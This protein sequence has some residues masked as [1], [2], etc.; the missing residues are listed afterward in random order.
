MNKFIAK[1]FQ[2]NKSNLPLI[3]LNFE[4]F[5]YEIVEMKIAVI[6]FGW[7]GLPL[8][9]SLL[10]KGHEIVGSTTTPS[11][12]S[13]LNA[14]G[15][16]AIEWDLTDTNTQQLTAFFKNTSICILNVPPNRKSQPFEVTAYG[17]NLLKA[18]KI[19]PINTHFIFVSST[20][21]YPSTIFDAH[22]EAIDRR[23][24]ATFNHL[25]YAEELLF[26]EYGKQLT[27]VRM[28]GLVGEERQLYRY[29][30]GKNELPNG[31]DC[32]NLIHL[33]DCIRLIEHI[34]EQK[35]WGKVI[36]ACSSE[37]PTRQEY[38]TALCQKHNQIAPTFLLNT[39]N[40]RCKIVNNS[41]S[42]KEL[43][44]TYRFENPIEYP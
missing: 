32:V 28:G 14:S 21:I 25:A 34:I 39:E 27:I 18:S 7:L 15:L 5:A 22:E 43:G 29:L 30:A 38:Y 26:Q 40:K 37:H 2:R 12:I 36:N 35:Y 20:G 23:E 16:N 1:K 41:K 10:Q 44:F 33:T 19:F 4:N 11:K 24:L 6:G 17:K 9:K 13:S 31:S 42:K 8:G 3:S